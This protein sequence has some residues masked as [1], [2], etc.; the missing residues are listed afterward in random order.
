L[1]SAQR[2]RSRISAFHVFGWIAAAALVA[3]VLKKS[4][5]ILQPTKNIAD[6]DVVI[7]GCPVWASNMATPMRTYLM[8]ENPRIKQ[9]ALFRTMG[10][11]GGKAA[12][13]R[14]AALCGRP[15]LAD[16]IVEQPALASDTWLGLAE[17]FTRQIQ[18]QPAQKGDADLRGP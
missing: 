8:R 4:P 5:P 15:S 14:M 13:A 18:T 9:V 16:L 11:S 6:Y 10:G 3:S 7:L 17:N 1:A 2:G 12:L